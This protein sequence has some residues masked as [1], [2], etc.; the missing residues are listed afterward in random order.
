M[1]KRFNLF[2]SVGLIV[3][4]PRPVAWGGRTPGTTEMRLAEAGWDVLD[5]TLGDLGR[6]VERCVVSGAAKVVVSAVSVG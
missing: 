4:A 5:T 6:E 1:D 3:R 2:A